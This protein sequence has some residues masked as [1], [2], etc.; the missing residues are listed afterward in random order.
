MRSDLRA[1]RE[2]IRQAEAGGHS[3]TALRRAFAYNHRLRAH[4]GLKGGGDLT[5]LP[6]EISNHMFRG[7][8]VR[9]IRLDLFQHV[10]YLLC[11]I[12]NV[13]ITCTAPL[14]LP[15]PVTVLNLDAAYCR[16]HCQRAV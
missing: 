14:P 1:L 3:D 13:I 15:L 8:H 4:T 12:C 2:H 16:T 10:M 7:K 6:E 9:V 11:A 5:G